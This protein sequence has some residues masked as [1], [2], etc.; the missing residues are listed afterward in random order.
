METNKESAQV[1]IVGPYGRV[2]LYTSHNKEELVKQVHEMLSLRK[3]WDD[4]DY[5]SRMMFCRMVPIES[6]AEEKG[7]GIG[8]QLYTD[9]ELL[10]TL[11]TRIKIIT[12]QVASDL[13]KGYSLFFSEF[14]DTF[15]KTAEI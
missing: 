5:L 1:E 12:I 2:Y 4:P 6:W 8:T 11:D 9:V 13:A 15:Y 14:V 7:Y 10:V 3:R